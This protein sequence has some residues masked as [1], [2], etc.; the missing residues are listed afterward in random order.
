MFMINGG[1]VKGFL[2]PKDKLAQESL[3]SIYLVKKKELIWK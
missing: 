3:K 1:F 2:T